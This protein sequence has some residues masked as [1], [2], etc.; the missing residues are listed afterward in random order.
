MDDKLC[1][2]CDALKLRPTKGKPPYCG[3]DGTNLLDHG[4]GPCRSFACRH[5]E[6]ML[7]ARAAANAQ[8]EGEKTR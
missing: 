5:W 3:M 6:Q 8:E 2:K 7:A 4:G 1:G